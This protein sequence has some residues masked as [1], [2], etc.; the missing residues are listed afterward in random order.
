MPTNMSTIKLS[1]TIEWAKKLNFGRPSAIGNFLEPALSCA[2]MVMQ[3]I[4][5]PPFSWWWNTQD[6]QFTCVAGTQ[7]YT[8]NVPNFGWIQSSS[9]QDPVTSKWWSMTTKLDLQA[10]S[11]QNRPLFI[12]PYSQNTATGDMK[13]RLMA[14]PDKAYPVNVHV[15]NAPQLFTSVN[16]T[17]SPIPDYMSY[18][19]NWG[20][21]ALMWLF[22]DDPRWA[23]ANQKFIAHLL[24]ASEGLSETQINIFLS[25]FTDFTQA[26]KIA[27]QQ[28][29]QGRGV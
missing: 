9:V 13:F 10:D 18:I 27:Q 20:F 1:N 8:Q 25:S 3:T 5:S 19:F 11:V 24:G 17:W 7:D 26:Q 28:G 21:L 6:V 4:V 12:A 15:Q 23:M 16:Q 2:N 22:A 14:V 29:F